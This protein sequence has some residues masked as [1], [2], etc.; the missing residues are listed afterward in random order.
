SHR[1]AVRA[2]AVLRRGDH[3]GADGG[4]SRGC[5]GVGCAS[6]R[7]G[8]LQ[9]PSSTAAGERSVRVPWALP[10]LMLALTGCA[11]Q[12]QPVANVAR[13]APDFMQIDIQKGWSFKP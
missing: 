3:F 7:Q 5:V 11:P 12:S 8:Y 2:E 6:R 13:S 10:V 9:R 4:R 1:G